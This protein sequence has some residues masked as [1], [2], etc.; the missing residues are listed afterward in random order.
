MKHKN[1]AHSNTTS[2]RNLLI[3]HGRQGVAAFSICGNVKVAGVVE[4]KDA[5][6]FL[7]N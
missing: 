7:K 1:Y 4:K 2:R 5:V 6:K 3:E